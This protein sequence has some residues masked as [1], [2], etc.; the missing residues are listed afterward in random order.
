MQHAF[1]G[2]GLKGVLGCHNVE[3]TRRDVS[4]ETQQLHFS[5]PPGLSIQ[6]ERRHAENKGQDD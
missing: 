5:G 2:A 3:R 6:R 4:A 1:H